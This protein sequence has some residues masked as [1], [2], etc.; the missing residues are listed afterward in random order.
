DAENRLMDLHGTTDL[1]G[2][3][4]PMPMATDEDRKVVRL[5]RTLRAPSF[6]PPGTNNDIKTDMLA[7]RLRGP[8]AAGQSPAP[9]PR[10]GTASNKINGTRAGDDSQNIDFGGGNALD[11]TGFTATLWGAIRRPTRAVNGSSPLASPKGA[12]PPWCLEAR[13]DQIY[14]WDGTGTP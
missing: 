2:A 12:M 9:F 1:G 13:Q 3:P 10:L 4:T 11:N 14:A 5:W 7:D 6:D 8:Q